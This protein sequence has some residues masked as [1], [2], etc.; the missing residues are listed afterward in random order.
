MEIWKKA[1]V[2]LKALFE[3]YG[4]YAIVTYFTIFFGTWT[5]LFFSIGFGLEEGPGMTSFWAAYA[6]TKVSQPL[7]IAVTVAITPIVAKVVRFIKGN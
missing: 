7:R 5:A 2:R 3:E 6:T 1:K 4:S